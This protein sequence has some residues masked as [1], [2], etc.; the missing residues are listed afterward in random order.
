LIPAFKGKSTDKLITEWLKAAEHEARNKD[1]DEDQKLRFFSNRL[2]G[3]AL[4]WQ[5]NYAKEQGN[6]LNYTDWRKD[7]VERFQ[8]SF[9]LAALRKKL[10]TLRQKPRENCRAFVSRLNSLGAAVKTNL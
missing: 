10:N 8:D 6:N 3:A 5:D 4:E 2:K 9:D 7:I 1:W